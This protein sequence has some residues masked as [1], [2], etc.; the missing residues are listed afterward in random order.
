[1]SVRSVLS[2][3]RSGS[4]TCE[5]GCRAVRGFAGRE[6]SGLCLNKCVYLAVDVD[7]GQLG[8][9][10][11]GVAF[12]DPCSDTTCWEGVV[13]VEEVH[14]YRSGHFFERELPCLL[15]LFASVPIDV[16]VVIVDGYV[17]LTHGPGLGRHLCDAVE[18]PVIGVAKSRYEGSNSVDIRRGRSSRPLYV[19]ATTDSTAA[20]E[21]VRGMHGQHRIPT[22]LKRVDRLARRRCSPSLGR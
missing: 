22:L 18:L 17:D 12:V 11:A 15:A 5:L 3:G 14:D 21:L 4:Y 10:A 20:A 13:T 6:S 9:V 2:G 16:D 19:T 1:M 7:Y 8:A